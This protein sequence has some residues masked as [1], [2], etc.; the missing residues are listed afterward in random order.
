MAVAVAAQMPRRRNVGS[1]AD[2]PKFIA[3]V[4][5][6]VISDENGMGSALLDIDNDGGLEWFVTSI[7]DTR[8]PAGNWGDER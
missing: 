6:S 4:D 5:R 8:V 1:Q 2:G 7:Y 3:E